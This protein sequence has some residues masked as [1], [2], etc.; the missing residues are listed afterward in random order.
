M[1]HTGLLV[2]PKLF[3]SQGSWL[4]EKDLT[5]K[6]GFRFIYKKK[7]KVHTASTKNYHACLLGFT[8]VT[9][10]KESWSVEAKIVLYA[11]NAKSFPAPIFFFYQNY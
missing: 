7:V 6:I 10:A 5:Y 2:R 1:T 8:K 9:L 3:G 4:D 11:V